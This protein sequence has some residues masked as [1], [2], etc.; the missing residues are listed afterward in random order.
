MESKKINILHL[1]DLLVR[2]L[3]D[4]NREV[5]EALAI[6][7]NFYW[8][9][10]EG[11]SYKMEAKPQEFDVGSLWDDIEFMEGAVNNPDLN[12]VLL[13]DQ[14]IPLLNYLSEVAKRQA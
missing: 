4:V 7:H 12:N 6:D 13:L 8:S 5:G 3:N 11:D 2:V 10:P 9:I 14:L 1:R